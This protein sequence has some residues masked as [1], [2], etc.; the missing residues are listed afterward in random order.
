[1]PYSLLAMTLGSLLRGFVMFYLVVFLMRCFDLAARLQLLFVY[2]IGLPSL[3]FV[4][5]S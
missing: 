2:I 3:G 5:P 4:R 1:M